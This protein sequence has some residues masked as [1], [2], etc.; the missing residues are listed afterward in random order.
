MEN[1]YIHPSVQKLKLLI[2]VV[3]ALLKRVLNII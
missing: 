2:K 3:I 1:Q